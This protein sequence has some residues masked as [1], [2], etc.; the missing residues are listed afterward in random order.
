VRA[1]LSP[2]QHLLSSWQKFRQLVS[3][4]RRYFFLDHDYAD[5]VEADWHPTNPLSPRQVLERV[6]AYAKQN[7]LIGELE[8]GTKLYRVRPRGRGW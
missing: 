6:L 5:D 8:T 3:H 1:R 4:G 2:S 7:N